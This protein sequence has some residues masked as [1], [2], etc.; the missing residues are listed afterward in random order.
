MHSS[1]DALSHAVEAYL[2]PHATSASDKHALLAIRIFRKKLKRDYMKRSADREQMLVAS[3]HAGRAIALAGAGAIHALSYPLTN[4]FHFPHG[5]G[6]AILFQGVM[7][8]YFTQHLDL[9]RLSVL[10]KALGT[11]PDK[12]SDAIG[13]II[14]Q[15]RILDG[16]GLRRKLNM[17]MIPKLAE[18]SLI[19]RRLWGNS[20][21]GAPDKLVATEMYHR[22][23]ALL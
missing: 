7:D 2:S 23:I 11:Q 18:Q 20:P 6:N 12:L 10:A 9:R 21:I 4:F 17:K 22:S 3:Y 13:K 8:Y 15:A 5:L 16:R 14:E 19:Y 1:I